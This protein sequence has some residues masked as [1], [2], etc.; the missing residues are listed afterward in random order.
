[1]NNEK[2]LKKSPE[3]LILCFASLSLEKPRIVMF[4]LAVNCLHFLC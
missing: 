3:T 2:N 1:M 4:K